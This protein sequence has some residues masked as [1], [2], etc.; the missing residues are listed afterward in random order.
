[1][2]LRNKKEGRR[3]PKR[4]VCVVL[5]F[6]KERR[7]YPKREKGGVSKEVFARK[8]HGHSGGV[9]VFPNVEKVL[10]FHFLFDIRRYQNGRID[11]INIE[12]KVLKNV[13]STFPGGR[14]VGF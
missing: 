3:Y 7:R 4:P 9:I 2:V 14:G 6:K 11:G 5:R 12:A 1:M 13:F 10:I 8:E